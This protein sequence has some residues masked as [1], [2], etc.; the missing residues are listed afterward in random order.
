MK[1]QT[2]INHIQA[3]KPRAGVEAP[4]SVFER[5]KTVYASD[6]SATVIGSRFYVREKTER[7]MISSVINQFKNQS[8]QA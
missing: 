4:I 2:H 8:V 3:P 7:H 5:M 1:A 6:C